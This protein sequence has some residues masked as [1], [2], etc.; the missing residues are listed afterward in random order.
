SASTRENWVFRACIC[1]TESCVP[2][3]ALSIKQAVVP[4]TILF[5]FLKTLAIHG[6]G[7]GNTTTASIQTFSCYV[8]APPSTIVPTLK[9]HRIYI[10][11]KISGKGSYLSPILC[12]S[13]GTT[14]VPL[15]ISPF[16]GGLTVFISMNKSVS[17]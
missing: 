2:W 13:L 10:P 9:L 17:T 12:S 4:D 16:H 7:R 6:N 3:E 5:Y 8:T 15:Y 11:W 14:S 1:I